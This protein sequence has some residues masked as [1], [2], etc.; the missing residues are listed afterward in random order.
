MSKVKL[1]LVKGASVNYISQGKRMSDYFCGM[2][3][4]CIF[5]SVQT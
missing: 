4:V 5:V 3:N 2:D 1:W